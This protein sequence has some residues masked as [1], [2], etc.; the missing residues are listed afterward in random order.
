MIFFFTSSTPTI[1]SG[2]SPWAPHANEIVTETLFQSMGSFME[3][4]SHTIALQ[5]TYCLITLIISAKCSTKPQAI[6]QHKRY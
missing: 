1:S 6:T 2:Y 4:L 3:Q 5:S